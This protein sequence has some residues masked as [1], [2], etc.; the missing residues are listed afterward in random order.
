MQPFSMSEIGAAAVLP[1]REITVL[2]WADENRVLTGGASAERVQ[3]HTRPY[4]R[5]PM[6]VLSPS[7]PCR[8]AVLWSAAQLMKC[9]AV[10]TPIPTV[11]GDVWTK[12]RLGIAYSVKGD[13]R[14]ELSGPATCSMGVHASG[15]HSTIGRSS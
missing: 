14:V 4:Q 10:D 11:A 9:L 2:Q 15:L 13:P 5:E 8:Q 12:S 7:H 6:D 1:P 3:W